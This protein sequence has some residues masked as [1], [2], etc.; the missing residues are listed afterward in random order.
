MYGLINASIVLPV[1]MSFASIIYRDPAFGP[2]MP[3]L[4]RLVLV[5]GLVHQLCFSTFSSLPFA[6]GQVQDAGLI[7]LSSMAS[8][9]VSFLTSPANSASYDDLQLLATVTIG[10]SLATAAL[11]VGLVMIGSAGLARYVQMLPT[12]VIGG[13]LAFIG[14]FCGASGVELMASGV[15]S[16]PSS[17][18]SSVTSGAPGVNDNT[19][20]QSSQPWISGTL[21]VDPHRIS[22][23]LAYVLPG[24]VGGC[25]IYFSV[26]KFQHMAVLPACIGLELAAFYA[27]LWTT[28]TTVKDATEKGW[29]RPMDDAPPWYRTWEYLRFDRV[30]WSALPPLLWTQFSMVL[31]V[32]LSSSLDVAAIELELRRPL[33]YDHE[34]STVGLSNIVSGL[35]GGYTGSYI[36]SQSIFSLRAGI[37]SRMAGY[38]LAVAQLIVLVLPFNLLAYVPNYL[39]GSLLVLICVDLLFEWLWDVR[40]RL[41]GPEYAVCLSTFALIQV[42]G[43]EYGI[44]AGVVLYAALQKLGLDVRGEASKLDTDESDPLIDARTREDAGKEGN[45]SAASVDGGLSLKPPVESSKR[46]G[47]GTNRED[48]SSSELEDQL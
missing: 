35:T 18:A 47:Y 5:S 15:S 16:T 41:T 40:H 43:V 11:G 6:I 1:L 39:F 28:G 21:V 14:W 24:V 2:F 22:E 36:F 29:I 44:L 37:R 31:V 33:D 12:S 13:Y 30:V 8:S 4:T 34:L 46:Y 10:L 9:V 20:L 7:F 32:A 25:A 45:G 42:L 3:V 23:L 26:R 48:G 27:F 17:S 38:C 19:D